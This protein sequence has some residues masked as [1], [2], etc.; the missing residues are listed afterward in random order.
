MVR[1]MF[2]FFPHCIYILLPGH[3]EARVAIQLVKNSKT[4]GHAGLPFELFKTG[5]KEHNHT[6]Q[7]DSRNLLLTSTIRQH[8]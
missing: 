8:S 5:G 2:S 6:N 4:S 1:C 3:N 7:N